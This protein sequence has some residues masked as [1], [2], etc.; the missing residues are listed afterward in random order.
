MGGVG[1]GGESASVE[2]CPQDQERRNQQAQERPVR[3][4]SWTWRPAEGPRGQ[5]NRSSPHL[6][7]YSHDRVPPLP[8]ARYLLANKVSPPVLTGHRICAG[9]QALNQWH[10]L[11]DLEYIRVHIGTKWNTAR[12]GQHL[13]NMS[14]LL[15]A[16][17]LATLAW[18]QPSLL[19]GPGWRQLP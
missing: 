1:C 17:G 8:A 16:D 7:T 18:R 4:P 13:C 3:A 19:G 12:P 9:L 2:G 14:G 11:L 6:L 5:S 15:S 10:F